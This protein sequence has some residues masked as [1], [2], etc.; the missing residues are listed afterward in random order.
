MLQD[1]QL[2][3]LELLLWNLRVDR[4]AEMQG[5]DVLAV[6]V[7]LVRLIG[8]IIVLFGK[9]EVCCSV[10][11]EGGGGAGGAGTAAQTREDDVWIMR[12]ENVNWKL[13]AQKYRKWRSNWRLP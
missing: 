10:V 12:V 1:F 11:L 13:T 6:V 9:V 2:L 3:R 7:R 5:R 4:L 8:R